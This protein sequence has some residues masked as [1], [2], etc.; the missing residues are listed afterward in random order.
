MIFAGVM[1]WETGESSGPKFFLGSPGHSFITIF[2]FVF[3]N[4]AFFFFIYIYFL[5]FYIL[6]M[7]ELLMFDVIERRKKNLIQLIYSAC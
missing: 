2:W 4:F 3:L 6:V 1:G 5:W 7:L